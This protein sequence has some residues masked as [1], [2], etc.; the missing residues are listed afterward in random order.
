VSLAPTHLR[1]PFGSRIKPTLAQLRFDLA[2]DRNLSESEIGSW[3][4]SRMKN[5]VNCLLLSAFFVFCFSAFAGAKKGYLTAPDYIGPGDNR[6]TYTQYA[7]QKGATYIENNFSGAGLIHCPKWEGSA[8]VVRSRDLI[9]TAAHLLYDDNSKGECELRATV[10][11][12]FFQNIQA[13]GSYGKKIPILA[14]TIRISAKPNCSK[15]NF[16]KDW[17]IVK[18]AEPVPTNVKP[19]EPF[20]VRSLSS[21]MVLQQSKIVAIGAVNYGLSKGSN[22]LTPTICEG[23]LGYVWETDSALGFGISCTTSPGNSGGPVLL[24]TDAGT[25]DYI[26]AMAGANVEHQHHEFDDRNY[27]AGAL[28]EGE[29]FEAVMS[30]SFAK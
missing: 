26:G 23:T 21:A 25:F 10:D 15:D 4:V 7:V 14:N 24:K 29:F 6:I 8:A 18:L 11:Q 22:I 30:T 12:C 3:R 27:S 5:A 2:L 9:A 20:N 13:N 28:F 16:G 17:A 1:T 19:F